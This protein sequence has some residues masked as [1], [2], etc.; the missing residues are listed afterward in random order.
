MK[1]VSRSFLSLAC[2]LSASSCFAPPQNFVPGTEIWKRANPEIPALEEIR[3]TSKA[4]KVLIG[5]LDSGMDYTVP[6]LKPHIHLIPSPLKM[7]RDYGVGLDLL[8]LDYFPFHKVFQAK[9]P[10]RSDE[11]DDITDDFMELA[12]GTHVGALAGGQNPE[13]GLLPVRVFPI[14]RTL[15][16]L[17]ACELPK[18]PECRIQGTSRQIDMIVKGIAFAAA[19]GARVINMSL[20]MTLEA[21]PPMERA[22]LVKKARESLA[23]RMQKTWRN[24]LMVVAAGNESRALDDISQSIPATL[25]VPEMLSVGALKD[26]KTI[27]NYSNT[28]AFVDVYERGSDVTSFVPGGTREAMS[29]TSMATPLVA[30]LAARLLLIDPTLTAAELRGLILNTAKIKILSVEKLED[31]TEDGRIP[32]PRTLTV[33]VSDPLAA[34]EAARLL[35]RQP[36]ERERLTRSPFPHGKAP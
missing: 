11:Y 4:H 5:V 14:A 35:V 26:K 28:G 22:V 31:S 30:N 23:A 17:K 13:I 7:G 25:D 16:D 12:H 3:E 33:R 18:S 9:T 36:G 27:A 6:R 15:E 32:A 10:D 24:V 21:L 8:G 34:I 20:G 29:G 2:L 19:Q 1:R